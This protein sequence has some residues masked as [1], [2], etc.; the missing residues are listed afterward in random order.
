MTRY[1]ERNQYSPLSFIIKINLFN[2]FKILKRRSVNL[3]LPSYVMKCKKP[4]SASLFI[5]KRVKPAVSLTRNKM[6]KILNLLVCVV[7][8]LLHYLY[9]LLLDVGVRFHSKMAFLEV[10]LGRFQS[11]GEYLC[12][13]ALNYIESLF[14]LFSRISNSLSQLLIKKTYRT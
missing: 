7:S 5:F 9:C 8:P 14:E 12:K 4:A 11:C 1:I 6:F 10:C 13:S 3:V 2:F